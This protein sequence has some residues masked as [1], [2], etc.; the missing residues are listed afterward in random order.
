MVHLV[1]SRTDGHFAFMLVR[2]VA[3]GRRFVTLD[4]QHA[5][6][7]TVA[8]S[9][10]EGVFDMPALEGLANEPGS[11]QPELG[12]ERPETLFDVF[13]WFEPA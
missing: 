7:A 13:V 2:A 5:R 10:T 12:P 9:R 4:A 8:R 1:L 3:H 6:W 11:G